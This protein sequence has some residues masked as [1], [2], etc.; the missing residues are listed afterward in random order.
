MMSHIR[1]SD[2]RRAA[3]AVSFVNLCPIVQ[4]GQDNFLMP[5]PRSSSES[6]T[7]LSV[8]SIHICSCIQQK[9][10]SLAVSSPSCR[11]QCCPAFVVDMLHH[12]HSSFWP[13]AIGPI[14]EHRQ[15]F[16]M[17]LPGSQSE[18]RLTLLITD[19]W[20]QSTSQ[21]KFG[22]ICRTLVGRTGKQD[23]SICR[24]RLVYRDPTA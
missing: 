16:D 21:E 12:P 19:Q 18:W 24:T 6:S 17:P 1:S 23:L 8:T 14:Q 7:A 13:L 10:D 4:Q 5:P 15:H 11:A 3:H 9:P 2:N 20:I 22:Y